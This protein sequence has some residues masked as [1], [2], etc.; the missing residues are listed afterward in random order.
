[1]EYTPGTRWKSAVCDTEV[2]IVSAPTLPVWLKCG[3]HDVIALAEEKPSN[4]ALDPASAD[5]SLIGK[6]YVHDASGLEVLCTKGGQGTLSV[7][8]KALSLKGAKPLP[9]SD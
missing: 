9:S 7:D 6:R 2:V 4:V 5:G 8:G 1:M 3:G